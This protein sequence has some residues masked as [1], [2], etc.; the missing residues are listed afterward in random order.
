[1]WGLKGVDFTSDTRGSDEFQRDRESD[2]V[3]RQWRRAFRTA[4]RSY[5]VSMK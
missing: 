2:L 5:A 4:Q 1:L 3:V